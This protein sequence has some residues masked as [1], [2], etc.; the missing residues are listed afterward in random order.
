M[1]AFDHRLPPARLGIEAPW[2]R[3]RSALDRGLKRIQ[4][5]RMISV[6]NRLPDTYLKESG[7]RRC[8][9]P[10]HARWAVYGED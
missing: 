1:T 9:I 6:L 7:L 8:D 3:A 4:Y 10:E 5:A 2:R